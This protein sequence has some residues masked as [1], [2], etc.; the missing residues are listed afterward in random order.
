MRAQII[1]IDTT[2][3]EENGVSLRPFPYPYR[4]ALA[5]C[6]DI[7]DATPELFTAVHRLLSLEEES[8]HGPGLGLEVA[9]SLFVWA[10]DPDLLGLLDNNDHPT[11]HAEALA[12]LCRAG[13]IDSLHA[14]GDFND[15]PQPARE[16]SEAAWSTLEHM[17]ISLKTWIN[18]GNENNAQNL[19]ARLGPSFV[20][21][22]PISPAY[23]ADLAV[24]HGIRYYWWHELAAMPL[25]C[26]KWAETR[27]A[28]RPFSRRGGSSLGTRGR[29]APR[30]A[31]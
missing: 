22:D 14:L 12:E 25:S 2:L 8:E 4:A 9:D 27:T 3:K 1:P 18:H 7:D 20:G 19:H 11:P 28:P 10:N 5:L 29:I 21:D 17:E 30:Q 15:G 31:R 13:W 6:S 23:H 24:E 26:P 16:R